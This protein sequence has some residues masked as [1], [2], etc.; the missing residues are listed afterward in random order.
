M[1]FCWREIILNRKGFIA[2]WLLAAFAALLSVLATLLY[3][4]A[5]GI[6]DT[7][8]YRNGLAAQY[9]AESGAVWALSY[10]RRNEFPEE[11]REETISIGDGTTCLVTF[12]K[13]TSG[14]YI[15]LAGEKTDTGSVR[16]LQLTVETD[17][18]GV[19]VLTATNIREL[20]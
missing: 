14:N 9:A 10:L 1:I 18:T 2:L 17:E 20:F 16:Y 7:A 4:A 3:G 15:D 13:E 6:R 19:R 11:K 5:Q 8:E 12:H